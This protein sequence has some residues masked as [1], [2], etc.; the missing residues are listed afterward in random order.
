MLNRRNA[1]LG[2]FV[3]QLGKRMAKKKARA[4]VPGVDTETKRPNKS[5]IIALLAAIGAVLMF[6]RKSGDDSPPPSVE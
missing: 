6:W 1:A 4:A 5:A 2:W 3:W